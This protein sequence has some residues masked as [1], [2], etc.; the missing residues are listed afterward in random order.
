[1]WP[2]SLFPGAHNFL[3]FKYILFCVGLQLCNVLQDRLESEGGSWRRLWAQRL[4][5]LSW[6]PHGSLNNRMWVMRVFKVSVSHCPALV[7]PKYGPLQR[8]THKL[9]ERVQARIQKLDG[10]KVLAH[11]MWS[12]GLMPPDA[13][14]VQP[15][16]MLPYGQRFETFSKATHEAWYCHQV[17]SQ[18]R[19]MMAG[20]GEI[21][22]LSW[23]P[24]HLINQKFMRKDPGTLTHGV[25]EAG[26]EPRGTWH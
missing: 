1:M 9:S 7:N 3:P 18:P 15:T 4:R 21:I 2:W 11:P 12:W 14:A 23:F 26:F 25:S 17:G 19:K 13:C 16:A 24:Y 10:V 22:F 5:G 20:F 6:L 8:V